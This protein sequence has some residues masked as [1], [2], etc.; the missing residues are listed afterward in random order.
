MEN[1]SF[2]MWNIMIWH[3]KQG[4]YKTDSNC[5]KGNLNYLTFLEVE[6]NWMHTSQS[7]WYLIF[8]F[9]GTDV[10]MHGLIQITEVHK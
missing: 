3:L 1:K 6:V 9:K 4:Q 8:T 5:E 10:S 2:E 7:K